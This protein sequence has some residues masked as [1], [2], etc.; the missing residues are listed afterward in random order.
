[1]RYK[2]NPKEVDDRIANVQLAGHTDFGLVTL[3][4][5]QS[6]A[7]LQLQLPDASWKYV[8]YV[9]DGVVVNVR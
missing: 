9:P 3:L 1:M 5:S 8:P 7:G 4:F 2:P 6:V